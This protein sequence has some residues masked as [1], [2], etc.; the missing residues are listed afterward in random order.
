MASDSLSPWHVVNVF[1]DFLLQSPSQ[2][3]ESINK[4]SVLLPTSDVDER[5]LPLLRRLSTGDWFTSRTSA[6]ALFAPAYP[7]A[8]NEAQVEMRRLFGDLCGD[9]TPM[10]RRAAAKS[11]GVS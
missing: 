11:L 3:A 5:F 7:K 2:A 9:D 4:V 6:C 1:A 8:G 10:V